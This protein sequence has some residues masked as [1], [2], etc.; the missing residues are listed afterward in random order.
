MDTDIMD[1][2]LGLYMFLW[3]AWTY[4]GI[5]LYYDVLLTFV[6]ICEVLLSSCD[7]Q[8]ATLFM[9]M[10]DIIK[11]WQDNRLQRDCISPSQDW[12]CERAVVVD[13]RAI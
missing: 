9:N 4:H 12:S 13:R 6:V 7:M 10:V 3:N 8:N 5:I 11:S 2:G 1:D